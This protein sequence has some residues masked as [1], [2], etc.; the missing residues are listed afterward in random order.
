M[1]AKKRAV[2]PPPPPAP[3]TAI[4]KAEEENREKWRKWWV[5]TWT[6]I[7]MIVGFFV[8]L[9]IGHIAVVGLVLFL[10]I[11]VFK[12]VLGIRQSQFKLAKAQDLQVAPVVALVDTLF[13]ITTDYFVIGRIFISRF[14]DFFASSSFLARVAKHHTLISFSLFCISFVAFVLTLRKQ[15][16][17][18]QFVGLAWLVLSL[19]L[20][21]VQSAFHISNIFEGLIWFF[22]PCGLVIIN[23]IFA[24]IFGFF[25]GRTPLIQL[26]PKKTWEGF[27]GGF[28]STWLIGFILCYFVA[29]FDFFVCPKT[30]L[31]SFDSP[32]CQPDPLFVLTAYDLPPAVAGALLKAGID[33]AT[34]HLYPVQLH[35]LVLATFA[36]IIA[37]FGGF[38]A[39]GFKRAFKIKDF[40]ETIPGHGGV[41]DRM[42]CQ[43]IMG[44]FAF[45]YHSNFLHRP[46]RLETL[47]AAFRV[48]DAEQQLAVY[49]YTT[50]YLTGQGLL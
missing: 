47:L 11:S 17:R 18:T 2:S 3:A 31:L 15:T 41:A 38:F 13:F 46:D 42:D 20:V 43:L 16:Y 25:F 39:S 50:N 30:S 1:P 48:L 37:P 10:Q 36:S 45:V 26:S 33:M 29:Q 24:Y 49:N 5:R 7:A 12:E 14:P 40:G 28:V 35:A 21:V 27:I 23:D 44:V 8:L 22:L 4:S 6:T 9:Y 32:T 34:V 19:L